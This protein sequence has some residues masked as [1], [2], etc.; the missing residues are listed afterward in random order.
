MSQDTFEIVVTVL[1]TAGIVL[2]TYFGYKI[3]Q[4]HPILLILLE[5]GAQL[6]RQTP[7]TSD[8]ELI[9]QLILL[10]EETGRI[11]LVDEEVSVS[12]VEVVSVLP[13]DTT[14]NYQG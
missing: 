3:R 6:A 12:N 7:S 4:F 14:V 9:E 11:E 8:D 2:F 5:I 10:L 1:G 13:V